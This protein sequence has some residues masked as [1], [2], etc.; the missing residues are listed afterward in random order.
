MARAPSTVELVGTHEIASRLGL[1]HPESVHAW[2]SRYADF[3]EPIAR[4]RI[5]FVWR[6]ADVESWAKKTGKGHFRKGG[7]R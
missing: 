6:W 5:G 3:P 4:L 1:A 7:K 2:R